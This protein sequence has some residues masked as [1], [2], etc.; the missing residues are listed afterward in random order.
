MIVEPHIKTT[1]N[2]EKFLTEYKY[3]T[4]ILVIWT[5][6]FCEIKFKLSSYIY[7]HFHFPRYNLLA[8]LL[9]RYGALKL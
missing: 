1:K 4:T 9:F 6:K 5:V 8:D 3:V 2:I 7:Y